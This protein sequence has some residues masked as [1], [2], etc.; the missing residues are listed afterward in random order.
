M[1]PG[2]VDERVLA[3]AR[4]SWFEQE[5]KRMLVYPPARPAAL[6]EP[7]AWDVALMLW[8][9]FEPDA[10]TGE[11]GLPEYLWAWEDRRTE[12]NDPTLVIPPEANKVAANRASAF[13]RGRRA[14][15]VL[16][17]KGSAAVAEQEM[18][19]E[20]EPSRAACTNVVDAASHLDSL[21]G[22]IPTLYPR[23]EGDW[24][25]HVRYDE[26][27][28]RDD[29]N[30]LTIHSW[31]AVVALDNAIRAGNHRFTGTCSAAGQGGR[32]AGLD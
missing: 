15:D 14:V 30:E 21:A 9:L 22:L 32:V 5:A 7:E 19:D 23:Q 29:T 18:S 3:L 17:T 8:L 2:T 26:L 24:C 4:E 16:S 13:E 10:L 31:A 11:L 27:G 12:L 25:W 28:Q 6:T 1:N 20:S